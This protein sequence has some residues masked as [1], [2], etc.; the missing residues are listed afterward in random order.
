LKIF[1]KIILLLFTALLLIISGCTSAGAPSS[2]VDENGVPWVSQR[3]GKL[4]GVSIWKLPSAPSGSRPDQSWL[5]L[6]SDPMGNIYISG[7]DHQ[8][9]SMLYQ[10]NQQDS[11]LRWVGDA[12][13]AS[14]DAD[15]WQNGETAEKFHTRPIFHEGRV[16]VATLD[17]SSMDNAYRSTRGF[18]W[19][20]YDLFSNDFIDLS[21]EEPNGVGAESLQIVTIQIDPINNLLYGMSIPENKVVRYDIEQGLTT[22]LG[23]PEAW[24]GYFYSNRYMWVDSRGRLYISGGTQ[25]NQWNQQEPVDVLDHIWFY[26][27]EHGFGETSFMLQGANSIEVGQWDKEHQSLYVS[28]DQGNIY[29][30]EDE[31]P[32][33]TY[34]GRPNFYAGESGRNKNKTWV[35]NLSADEEKIY[36]GRSDNFDIA[37]EIWEFDI[38]SGDSYKLCSLR[39]LDSRAGY[40]DFITGYDSWD[41]QGN[42]YMSAFAMFDRENVYMMGINPVRLKL[43]KGIISELIEVNVQT[44]DGALQISRS[45]ST[46]NSLEILYQTDYLNTSDDLVGSAYGE[47][48]FATGESLLMVDPDELSAFSESQTTGLLFSLI[49][50]GNDYVVGINQSVEME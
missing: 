7:H 8:T 4:D 40:K 14:L 42:F 38:A 15:N 32:S 19:Y 43:A 47:L 18:H 23:K 35:F 26:D 41:N 1:N 45:G 37:N 16:Y 28:D 33:W 30:F 29:R 46:E 22:V 36:I 21:A 44:V 34:L 27:D 17:K 12:R 48:L 49:A 5:A 13:Q 39:E 9:N 6:G 3:P 10:L 24:T 25:R 50:D 31:G 2:G 11:I 20:A